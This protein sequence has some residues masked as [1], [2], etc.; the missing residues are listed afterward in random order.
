MLSGRRPFFRRLLSICG[1]VIDVEEVEHGRDPMSEC[2]SECVPLSFI[3]IPSSITGLARHS[4]S[5]CPSVSRVAFESGSR[6]SRIGPRTFECSSL[7]SICIPS[8]VEKLYEE[9]FSRCPSLTRVTFESRSQLSCIER[10][11]FQF[12]RSLSSICIPSSLEE[13]GT[14]CFI[15]CQSLSIVTFESL[16]SSRVSRLVHLRTVRH[17]RQ[18]AFLPLS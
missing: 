12:C 8:S 5:R 11:A 6:L 4:F 17:F 14:A 16:R 2:F 10:S 3:C 15:C 13:L 9:C 18:S 7:R 1:V